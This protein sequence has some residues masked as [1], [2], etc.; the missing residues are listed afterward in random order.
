MAFIETDLLTD[1]SQEELDGIGKE[2]AEEQ[3]GDP[4]PIAATIAEQV[5]KVEDYTLR[6]D[7]PELRVKRLVR[8]LVLYELYARLQSIP[9]KRKSKYDEA[10]KELRDIRDGKFKDLAVEEPPPAGMS[11]NQG[12]WGSK[13]KIC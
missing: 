3:P 10:M 4:D 5:Q 12:K 6:Y 1:I 7:V 9:D 13:K 8:A 2:L 11:S